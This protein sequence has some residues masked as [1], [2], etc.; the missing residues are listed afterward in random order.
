MAQLRVPIDDKRFQTGLS[1]KD[2]LAQ[3]GEHRARTEENFGKAQLTD[4][5]RAF[6]KG[7]TQ[8]KY[9]VML[10]ENW[11]GDVHR[12]SP[13]LARVA[14]ALPGAEMRV[15]FRDQN[16]D[17]TDCYLNNSY[18]SI[19]I[20]VMF[21]KEWN[22]IGRW[23]ERPSR[24]T[25]VSVTMRARLVDSVPADQREPAIAEFRKRMNEAYEGP[26]GLWHDTVKE[27]RQIIE[28]KFGLLPKE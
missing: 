12:N 2:Y 3:M 15:F 18:R 7:I 13:M 21:D 11:C 25:S 10:A 17:L 4:D 9:I 5:E 26:D 28:T 16:L 20:F 27:V 19:P 22:E 23:V 1:W 14:E 6:F 24:A 8:V